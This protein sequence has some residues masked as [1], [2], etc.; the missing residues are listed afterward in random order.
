MPC[1]IH[2]ADKIDKY[3]VDQK[4]ADEADANN[5]DYNPC[6]TCTWQQMSERIGDMHADE[7]DEAYERQR[8]LEYAIEQQIEM[9]E[10]TIDNIRGNSR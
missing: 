7:C 1:P 6:G 3:C 2:E 10:Q 8:E 5:Q 9:R 4:L